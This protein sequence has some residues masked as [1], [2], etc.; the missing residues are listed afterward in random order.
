MKS[1][2]LII[3]LLI[4]LV[5]SHI[6]ENKVWDNPKPIVTFGLEQFEESAE[7]FT[8]QFS[9]E[10]FD[11]DLILG[12]DNEFL[13]LSLPVPHPQVPSLIQNYSS[14][15]S[16]L[17]PDEISQ[18]VF[19]QKTGRANHTIVEYFLILPLTFYHPPQA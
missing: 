3:P 4:C 18:K 10:S 11:I 13:E 7:E 16:P 9:I 14:Y 17:V 8:E 1:F 5:Y 15:T 12:I 19:Y 2:F 6:A